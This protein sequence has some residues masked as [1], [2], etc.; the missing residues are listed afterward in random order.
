VEE[1]LLSWEPTTAGS[2]TAATVTFTPDRTMKEGDSIQIPLGLPGI[3]ADVE[4]G[5][6]TCTPTGQSASLFLVN[7]TVA[8][9]T[10]IL[11]VADG[12]KVIRGAPVTLTIPT[13]CKIFNPSIT[14]AENDY[15][16]ATGTRAVSG[17]G[18]ASISGTAPKLPTLVMAPVH[19]AEMSEGSETGRFDNCL[20]TGCDAFSGNTH[21]ALRTIQDASSMDTTWS[22]RLRYSSQGNRCSNTP[23]AGEGTFPSSRYCTPRSPG[24]V[25][26]N[27]AGD[28]GAPIGSSAAGPSFGFNFMEDNDLCRQ[29]GIRTNNPC[30]LT[31]GA[32]WTVGIELQIDENASSV[33]FKFAH[34]KAIRAGSTLTFRL[35]TSAA[36]E[37][38]LTVS[39]LVQDGDTQGLGSE[40]T[41]WTATY[42]QEP[43]NTEYGV[44]TITMDTPVP[45]GHIVGGSVAGFN[46][47]LA[48]I[49]KGVIG[50]VSQGAKTTLIFR[51]GGVQATYNSLEGAPLQ[52][53]KESVLPFEIVEGKLYSFR[54]Y[55]YNGRF[56]SEPATTSVSNRAIVRPKGVAYIPRISVET[57]GVALWYNETNTPE[58]LTRVHLTFTPRMPLAG[59]MQISLSLP[60]FTHE[61]SMFA[62]YTAEGGDIEHASV[63][64]VDDVPQY[65]DFTAETMLTTASWST[66]TSMLV[67]TVSE[68]Q[69]LY[70]VLTIYVP[71]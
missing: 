37:S 68:G 57:M 12:E 46:A 26:A 32:D 24:Y 11:T 40:I 36:I 30:A 56:R 7:V 54:V 35:P 13:E 62:S 70:F 69:V 4:G 10:I 27:G 28:N 63:Q 55:A 38:E 1:V 65:D 42:V 22:G 41:T 14:P 52:A 34:A 59:G 9:S 67:F 3:V 16:T 43:E 48:F 20:G 23:S 29:H 18:T 21:F 49:P 66:N 17:Y 61:S 5:T 45:A 60:G 58:T 39:V 8:T 19:S 50:E 53:Y 51:S 31:I 47:N 15:F 25:V 6:S 33:E 2:V 44:M 71:V 64:V